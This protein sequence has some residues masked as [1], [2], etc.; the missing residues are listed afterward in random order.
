MS[1]TIHCPGGLTRSSV[2]VKRHVANQPQLSAS[3]LTRGVSWV[4]WSHR[5]LKDGTHGD[6]SAL[7]GPSVGADCTSAQALVGVCMKRAKMRKRRLGTANSF[8][9]DGNESS[10]AG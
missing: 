7:V 8:F 5:Q 4:S 3:Q 6:P 10:L 1:E 2:A 9:G